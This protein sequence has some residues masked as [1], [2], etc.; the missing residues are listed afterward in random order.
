[1]GEVLREAMRLGSK[2]AVSLMLS[3]HCER[4]LHT[5]LSSACLRFS[6]AD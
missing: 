1:M 2:T 6:S 4:G 5:F 3:E